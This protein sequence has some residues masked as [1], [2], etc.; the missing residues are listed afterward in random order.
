MTAATHHRYPRP[1]YQIHKPISVS[2][3]PLPYPTPT[4]PP[5]PT[6]EHSLIPILTY[7]PIPTPI[8]PPASTFPIIPTPA[9]PSITSPACS[10]TQECIYPLIHTLTYLVIPFPT[11]S[12]YKK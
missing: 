8:H 11:Y 10:C 2:L 12:Y 5:I 7:P 3:P 4:Y 9:Y 6:P 1:R